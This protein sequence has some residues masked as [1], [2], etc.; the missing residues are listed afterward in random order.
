MESP[1][2]KKRNKAFKRSFNAFLTLYGELIE[3]YPDQHV[4]LC[5]GKVV[6]NDPD[7]VV[8]VER[9]RKSDSI[10][11][12]DCMIEYISKDTEGLLL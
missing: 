10:N 6:D 3:E 11:L 12:D 4:A 9:V 8:L 2:Q 1:V 7:L 5:N